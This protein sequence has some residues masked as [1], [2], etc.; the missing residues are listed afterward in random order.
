MSRSFRI[1]WAVLTLL[2]CTHAFGTEARVFDDPP[3]VG[4]E[5]VIIVTLPGT[6]LEA[7]P[8]DE[9]TR[10]VLRIASA[11]S[12]ADGTQYDLRY[13]GLVPGNYD[14]RDY[15]VRSDGSP[16]DNLPKVPVR[17]THLL[18]ETHSGDLV[19]QEMRSI[20]FLGGYRILVNIVGASWLLLLIPIYL[21]GRRKK[22]PPPPPPPPLP[23]LADHLRPLVEQAAAG[24]LSADGQSRLER[25]LLWHWRKRLNLAD[26]D[27]GEA[28]IRLRAH[29]EAGLLLSAL[30]NWLHRPPGSASAVDIAAV[31]APYRSTSIATGALP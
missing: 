31:L 27:P 17:V 22:A 28:L 14:L 19:P 30:E 13:I 11:K 15:L 1:G 3:T 4:M 23:T 8:V 9:K 21:S 7:R 5:G 10:L 25:L 29:P 6:R 18:P 20:P 12:Q 26:G 16:T 24:A 2:L